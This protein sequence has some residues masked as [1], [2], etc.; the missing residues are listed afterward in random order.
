MVMTGGW[1]IIVIPTL[2]HFVQ[3]CVLHDKPPFNHATDNAC[4]YQKQLSSCL[5]A[6]CWK[7]VALPPSMGMQCILLVHPFSGIA[8]AQSTAMLQAD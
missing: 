5:K 3:I 8:G 1:L 7:W 2:V 6:V 4:Q